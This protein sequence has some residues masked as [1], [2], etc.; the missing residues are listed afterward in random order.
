MKRWGRIASVFG[1]LGV[2]TAAS[3]LL[4]A[5]S[6]PQPPATP[7]TNAGSQGTEKAT[8]RTTTRL[9]QVSVIAQD[10]HGRLVSD[11]SREDFRLFEEGQEQKL[12]FFSVTSDHATP[13]AGTS[14]PPGVWT[15][16][17]LKAAGAPANLT[18]ILLDGLN[19]SIRDV[20]YARRQLVSFLSQL[21]PED[22]VALY[23]LGKDLRLV[24]DFTRDAS[25][26]LRGLAHEKGYNGPQVISDEEQ[27]EDAT[28]VQAIDQFA[29]D[30]TEA[31]NENLVIYRAHRTTDALE[32]IAQH[33]ASIPGR[34]SLIW[35]SSAFPI[36]IGYEGL[37]VRNRA[38]GVDDRNF[39]DLIERTARALN[40]ANL[41]VY[42]VD[43][44]G[45]VAPANAA[46]RID[47]ARMRPGASPVT[48]TATP[49]EHAID[50][51]IAIADRTGGRAFYNTNDLSN[52]IRLAIEDGRVVYT[53]AYA[54]THNEWNGKYRRIKVG[55]SRPGVHLH[56]RQGY[57]ATPDQ[58]VGT[59]EREKMVEQLKWS[60]MNASQIGLTARARRSIVNGQQQVVFVVDADSRDL[61]F[62]EKD[63]LYTTDLLFV[64]CHK[65]TNGQSVG[66]TTNVVRLKLSGDQYQQ[67]AASGVRVKVTSEMEPEAEMIRLILLDGA[68]GR[69]GS[70]DVPM[71]E[72]AEQ[73]KAPP[74]APAATPGPPAAGP[75][76]P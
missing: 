56:Y 27:G 72:I 73:G 34:K 15:N 21:R 20:P 61:R 18:L 11:M 55:T 13:T 1:V 70:V 51:M 30:A 38:I 22:R 6:S 47:G 37:P 36:A 65:N 62:E 2:L 60:P 12:Q 57:M 76:K 19:T 44:N 67:V 49:Q 26:L 52:A 9:V 40:D 23:I 14:P 33:V 10:K 48:S 58:P 50:T 45:L 3:S 71:A 31:S 39:M 66:G 46:S 29:R 32:A 69:V 17:A 75:A 28:G 64:T 59:T 43:A 35:V 53:L 54:P 7:S 24:Q 5:Q 42:P 16:Q 8:I 68:T 74:P 63:G 41:A 25:S 4:V